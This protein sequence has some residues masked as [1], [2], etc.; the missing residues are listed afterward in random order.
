MNTAVNDVLYAFMMR[1]EDASMVSEHRLCFQATG[2]L[3]LLHCVTLHSAVSYRKSA[4]K[5]PSV[6]YR[7][8]CGSTYSSVSN[9]Y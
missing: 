3:T 1:E 7:V 5:R 4:T 2:L 9:F 8:F 6:G